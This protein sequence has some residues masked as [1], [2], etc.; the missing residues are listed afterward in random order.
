MELVSFNYSVPTWAWRSAARAAEISA[1]RIS[2]LYLGES[3]TKEIDG[4]LCVELYLSAISSLP[5]LVKKDESVSKKGREVVS[6]DRLQKRV[7]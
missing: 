5:V 4:I 3:S 7:S 1:W 2:V 6:Q